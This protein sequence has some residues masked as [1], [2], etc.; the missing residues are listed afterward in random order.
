MISTS[1][2]WSPADLGTEQ[3]LDVVRLVD[4]ATYGSNPIAPGRG[5]GQATLVHRAVLDR[6][7]IRVIDQ[8]DPVSYLG[9]TIEFKKFAAK[10]TDLAV[11][12]GLQAATEDPSSAGPT[13]PPSTPRSCGWWLPSRRCNAPG[14]GWA[15]RSHHRAC[16]HSRPPDGA[17][18]P[19][20]SERLE[21]LSVARPQGVSSPA[22]CGSARDEIPT[23]SMRVGYDRQ[24][25]PGIEC[26]HGPLR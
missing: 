6:A 12:R 17:G 1:W 7:G 19:S 4:P 26:G 23:G 18:D 9:V 10:T 14:W 24:L 15:C 25:I 2:T 16:A 21:H 20:A 8:L 3:L 5:P 22:G 11:A 13:C